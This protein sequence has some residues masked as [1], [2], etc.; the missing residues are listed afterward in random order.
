VTVDLDKATELALD[1]AAREYRDSLRIS[2]VRSADALPYGFDPEGWKLFSITEPNTTGPEKYVAVHRETGE[3]RTCEVTKKLPHLDRERFLLLLD[4]LHPQT[5]YYAG[6]IAEKLRGCGL[7]V[8]VAENETSISIEGV[9]VNTVQPEW[10]D[11]GILPE[12]ILSTVF[13]LTTGEWPK[14]DLVGMGFRYRQALRMLEDAW[15]IHICKQV[16]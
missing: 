14:T 1:F 2:P 9:E 5:T 4:D 10:G 16:F 15:D 12:R 8:S 7:K 13:R 11:P 6:G 3:T